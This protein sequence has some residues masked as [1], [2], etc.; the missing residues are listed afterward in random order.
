MPIDPAIAQLRGGEEIA[1]DVA[2]PLSRS[3]VEPAWSGDPLSGD[4]HLPRRGLNDDLRIAHDY[5]D[6][7]QA[8]SVTAVIESTLGVKPRGWNRDP[9]YAAMARFSYDEQRLVFPPEQFQE[10]E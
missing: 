4:V 6:Q 9:I 1:L 8:K 2:P 3:A 5:L 10:P 7:L